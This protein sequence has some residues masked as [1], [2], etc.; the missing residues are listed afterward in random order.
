MEIGV[1]PFLSSVLESLGYV[2]RGVFDARQAIDVLRRE[3]RRWRVIMLDV[4][5]LGSQCV[6]V[7]AQLLNASDD[8]SIVC[9]GGRGGFDSRSNSA[10]HGLPEARVVFLDK[11][12]SVLSVEASLNRLSVANDDGRL[13][14]VQPVDVAAAA[15]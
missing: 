14:D 4:E 5:G 11:P 6:P 15:I 13:T 9:V 10:L 2:S 7:C 8:I 3:P 1:Q 12:L